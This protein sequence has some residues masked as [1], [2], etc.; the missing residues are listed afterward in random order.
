MGQS[1]TE[2]ASSPSPVESYLPPY[3]LFE[4]QVVEEPIFSSLLPFLPFL[5]PSILS[6]FLSSFPF[7]LFI[8]A[9][10]KA[11]GSQEAVQVSPFSL[12]QGL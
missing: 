4:T 11:N 2:R 3:L 8:I 10:V 7:L 6:Y 12:G 1:A 9:P 5:L